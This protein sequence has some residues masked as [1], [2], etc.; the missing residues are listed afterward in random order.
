[1]LFGVCIGIAL[2][3]GYELVSSVWEGVAR[4]SAPATPDRVFMIQ[5]PLP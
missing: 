4:G 3:S 5:N 1:M 2:K